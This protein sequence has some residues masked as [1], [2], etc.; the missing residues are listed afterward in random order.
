MARTKSLI[1]YPRLNDAK[2]NVSKRWY[3]EYAFR[4]PEDPEKVYRY[5][6]YDGLC[7]GTAEDRYAHARDIIEERTQW[8]KSGAYLTEVRECTKPVKEVEDYL[9]VDSLDFLSV[10][11]LADLLGSRNHCFGCFTEKYPVNYS[12][13]ANKEESTSCC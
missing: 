10:D 12:N 9:D 7:S 3:V 4:L 2:G 1:C 6:T 13:Q 8:L 5:R 11:N